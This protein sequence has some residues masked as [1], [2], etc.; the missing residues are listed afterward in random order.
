MRLIIFQGT[1]VA[2]KEV[3]LRR[4]VNDEILK[5]VKNMY[6]RRHRFILPL[7]SSFI[8]AG[9][10]SE[11][12]VS[13]IIPY[14]QGGDMYGWIGT[15]K[16]SEFPLYPP[17]MDD[18]V[19]R[20][21]F[22]FKSMASLSEALAYLHSKIEGQWCGHFDIKPHNILLFQEGDA[23]VWKMSDFGL[24]HMKSSDDQGTIGEIG[25]DEYQ[26]PE[27][28]KSPIDT[29]HG[30][31]F[32]VWSLGCVFLELLMV[33]VHGWT[34]DKKREMK[35]ILSPNSKFLFRAPQNVSQW[36]SHVGRETPG[37]RISCALKIILQM[38]TVEIKDRI[39]AFDAAIDLLELTQ[40]DMP[41]EVYREKCS[42]ITKGQ[43]PS[44][45]LAHFY[46]PVMRIRGD[47]EFRG[48]HFTNSRIQC[49]YDARWPP[50]P[51]L[52]PCAVPDFSHTGAE[53]LTTIPSHYQEEY[54]YGRKQ[55]LDSIG[56]HYAYTRHVALVGLGGVGKSHL[57]YEFASRE[58]K[59]ALVA[60]KSLHTFW[61]SCRN[62]S[63]FT[64]SYVSIAKVSGIAL[65]GR[66]ERKI[67]RAVREWLL[68]LDESWIM[69]LDGVED[70]NA[71]W[72]TKWCPFEQGSKPK[73][74][75]LITTRS[76]QV[77]EQLCYQPHN[78]LPVHID[79]LEIE[80]S[81]KLLLQGTGQ[82][83]PYDARDATRLVSML[84][85]PTLIKL[86]SQEIR[87]RGQGGQTISSFADQLSSRQELIAE[88]R[89]IDARD[90]KINE[91]KAV[92]RIYDLVFG[93]HFKNHIARRD[94]FKVICFFANDSI[95]RKWMEFEFGKEAAQEAF[96]FFA[97][98]QYIR[99]N[100]EPG[101]SR[102]T[103]HTL[104]QSIF[105]AWMSDRSANV[106][107]D[108]WSAHIRALWMIYHDYRQSRSKSRASERHGNRQTPAHLVKLRYKDHVEEFLKYV[109]H[110][111][112]SSLKFNKTAADAVITFARWFDHENRT[113]VGQRLLRL[114][115]DQGIKDDTG[116]R[117]E[118]QA[119]RDLVQSFTIS[120]AGRTKNDVL[121]SA[122][123]EY[124]LALRAALETGDP[125]TLWKTR[126][127]SIYLHCRIGDYQAATAELTKLE[128][129]IPEIPKAQIDSHRLYLDLAQCKAKCFFT[130]GVENKDTAAL[131]NSRYHWQDCISQITS[132]GTVDTEAAKSL[133]RAKGGLAS[134][135][136]AK[137]KHLGAFVDA[138]TQIQAYGKDLGNEAWDIY[139]SILQTRESRYMAEAREF[140]LHKHVVDARRD[141]HAAQL[142]IWLW[143]ADSAVK[144]IIAVKDVIKPLRDV[145]N[146]YVNVIGLDKRDE[147]VRTT[148]YYLRDGLSFLRDND[149]GI[150][151]YDEELS[152][153]VHEYDLRWG[154]LSE[155]TD[156]TIISHDSH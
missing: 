120:A 84:Y 90:P 131:E 70:A 141:F 137:M 48:E 14:A 94:I 29:K 99:F 125:V 106:K 53:S 71:A 4:P 80:D 65:Q 156:F 143:R 146:D 103:T 19:E 115:I 2:C 25:T 111:E 100:D 66:S 89:Q 114:V 9:E 132:S 79:S 58:R 150:T 88:L 97:D 46:D 85:L 5:E 129:L 136:L 31:S 18:N 61:V 116:R 92:K 102:Y 59:S 98:H 117:S 45:S 32:D 68:N 101:G 148:A 16:P 93:S 49:L 128:S 126:R 52:P 35:K 51:S 130:Q 149:K 40:P 152:S 144:Q 20:E 86:I 124:T 15:A 91:L 21:D 109:D 47:V 112:L 127:E 118:C 56:F 75:F 108:F 10:S 83:G 142:Q 28:H 63:A 153:L 34:T 38:L 33:L 55:M 81:V 36:A 82:I 154:P 7:L 24:S 26:P 121:N 42:E 73:G 13:M 147:D 37:S 12:I 140:E 134:S 123:R 1:T 62:E 17:S 104:V 54:F 39:H 110:H 30:P 113:E 69:V 11:A 76:T 3:R 96:T 57:A 43:D 155:F 41:I 50:R 105:Q 151:N 8:V 27:Y 64:N 67:Q 135:C 22:I 122:L 87:H 119:R 77:G 95:D 145:L 74:R 72:S 44:P 133:E 107:R 139:D 60:G 78:V 23:W 138:N 6:N